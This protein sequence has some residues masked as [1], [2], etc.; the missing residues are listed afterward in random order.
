MGHRNFFIVS[1]FMVFI[2][3]LSG[4]VS[5]QRVFDMDKVWGDMRVLGDNAD[6]DSGRAI[7]C[8]DIN[9]DG[10]MDIIIGVQFADP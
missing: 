3:A 2:L 10:F 5:G 4:M 7:A 6:D 9:G 8:G 1:V